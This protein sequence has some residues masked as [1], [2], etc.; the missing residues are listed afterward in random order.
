MYSKS[1]GSTSTIMFKPLLWKISSFLCKEISK[2][3]LLDVKFEI[4][5]HLLVIFLKFTAIG[6]LNHSK[7][8]HSFRCKCWSVATVNKV[9]GGEKLFHRCGWIVVNVN[10]GKQIHSLAICSKAGVEIG[11]RKRFIL[12]VTDDSGDR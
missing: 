7:S 1:E 5:S 3:G 4:L 11:S 9:T 12:G 6:H 8:I 2:I 10:N